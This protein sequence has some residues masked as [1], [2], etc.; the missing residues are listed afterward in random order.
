MSSQFLIPLYLVGVLS[1]VPRVSAQEVEAP[2]PASD[3]VAVA[4]HVLAP[5]A[6]EEAQPVRSQAVAA[7]R[8]PSPT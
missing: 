4:S 2:S 8:F 3:Y 1:L 5:D 6:T 7:A